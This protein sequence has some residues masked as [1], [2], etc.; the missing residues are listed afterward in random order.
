MT[1]TG[2]TPG[3]PVLLEAYS[4]VHE[5]TAYFDHAGRVVRTGTAD[6]SG[7]VSWNDIRPSSNTRVR[8]LQE[9]CSPPAKDTA[10]E[11]GGV[12][13]V[14]TAL[15]LKVTRNSSR[16]YTFSG[17]SIPAR[18]GGLIV[19]VYRVVGSTCSAGIEPR[20]CPGERFVGQ[21]RANSVNGEHAVTLTFGGSFSG[22][23]KFVLKTGRDAQNAPGRSN[24]RDVAIF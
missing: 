11:R 13:N 23:E 21:S 10:Q 22:R 15:F 4:Q 2:A 12:I 18:T 14:R 17:D 3:S 8:A 24:V 5:G 1:A 20:D 16:T 19:S 6:A 7:A 9:F